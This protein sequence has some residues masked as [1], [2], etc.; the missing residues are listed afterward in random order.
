MDI[1]FSEEKNP[2]FNFADLSN[3]GRNLTMNKG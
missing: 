3:K 2:N 1:R